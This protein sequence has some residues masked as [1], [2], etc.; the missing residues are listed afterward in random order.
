MPGGN[1]PF[2]H[3]ITETGHQDRFSHYDIFLIEN[4]ERAN[5][6]FKFPSYPG[7]EITGNYGISKGDHGPWTTDHQSFNFKVDQ[8]VQERLSGLQTMDHQAS[9][10]KL[11]MN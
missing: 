4:P 10:S 5:Y 2:G 3:G 7:V 1:H 11:L 8:E 6:Y 9:C